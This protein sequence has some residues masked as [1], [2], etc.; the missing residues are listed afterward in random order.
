MTVSELL[1]KIDSAELSEWVAFFSLENETEE[2]K[3]KEN[4][5]D[6]LKAALS[7]KIKGGWERQK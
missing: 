4:L 6:R 3:K 7:T 1:S 5:T 2:E